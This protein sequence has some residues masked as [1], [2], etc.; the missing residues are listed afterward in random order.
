[1]TEAWSPELQK[2]GQKERDKLAEQARQQAEGPDLDSLT[3]DELLAMAAEQNVA[4]SSSAT[5][6]EIV[7]ALRALSGQEG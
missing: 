5:K 4:M 3:K 6:A 7:D 1:M 2:L